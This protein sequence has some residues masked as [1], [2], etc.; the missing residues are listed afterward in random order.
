M[1]GMGVFCYLLAI[2]PVQDLLLRPLEDQYPPL[3]AEAETAGVEA[4]A[5][6]VLG[7]GTI[8]GS[9][10]AGERRDSLAAPALKRLV[11]AFGLRDIFTGVYALSGGKVFDY[12]QEAEADT[13]AR[14]LISLGLPPERIVRETKSRNTWQNARY[15]AETLGYHQ[16]ILVTSAYHIPRS[17]FCFEQNGISVIPAPTDYYCQRNRKYDLFSFLPSMEA[18]RGTWTA[19]HEYI[20]L[21]QYRLVYR[22]KQKG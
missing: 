6:V 18:F 22:G 11:Y 19:L 4:D 20:G 7:G 9:P 2:E 3:S 12:G 17:V 16:V 14:V 21:V 15:V 8:Q 5:L 13:A 1:L 10:E